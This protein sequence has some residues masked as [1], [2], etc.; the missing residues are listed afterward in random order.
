MSARQKRPQGEGGGRETPSYPDW[1][2]PIEWID[3]KIKLAS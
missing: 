2:V 1:R 3:P